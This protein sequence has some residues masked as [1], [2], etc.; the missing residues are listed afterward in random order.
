MP[1][2]TDLDERHAPEV[3]LRPDLKALGRD[4]SYIRV[5]TDNHASTSAHGGVSP[6][7]ARSAVVSPALPAL[8]VA[9]ASPLLQRCG[10]GPCGCAEQPQEEPL[11]RAP[12]SPMAAQQAE[13]PP[14]VHDALTSPGAPLAAGDR[15][16]FESRFGQDFSAVRVHTGAEA[17]DSARAVGAYGYTVGNHV[18]LGRNV[19]P[20]ATAQGRRVLAHELAHVIQQRGVRTLQARLT[21]GPADSAA[22]READVA[23]ELAAKGETAAVRERGPTAVVQRALSCPELISP[24]DQ[25]A[26]NGIGNPAHDAIEDY[27]RGKVGSRFW[28]QVIPGASFAPYRTEDPDPRH[29]EPGSREEQVE[30]QIIGGRGGPGTPDLGYREARSPVVELAEVKPAIL[31]YGAFGGLVEGAAQLANYIDKGMSPENSGWRGRRRIKTFV[32]MLPER[33]IWPNSLSTEAGRKIAVGWCGPGLVGYR[34]LSAEES[35]TIIC[36][37]SDQKQIDRFLN[38]ALDR[39]QSMV[40]SYIDRSV[41][42][43]LT[44]EIQ[45]LTIHDGLVLLAKHARGALQDLL[46]KEVG[47]GVG[48]LVD[49]LPGDELVGRAAMWIEDQVGQQAETMLRNLVLQVKTKLLTEVRRHLKDRLRTYLQESLAAVCAAA[50][51]GASVSVAQLLKKL[52]QDLGKMFGESVVEVAKA[53]A[54]AVAKELAKALLIAVLVV[55]AV[56][57]VIVF[58][59]EILAAIAAAGEFFLAA[60]AAIAAAGGAVTALGPNLQS[61]ISDVVEAVLETAPAL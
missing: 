1:V 43:M 41:D 57:A 40:D 4:F 2:V 22:E 37:V 6:M 36:G 16:F 8:T 53:W 20:I 9:P 60:G 50:A 24:T 28:Q 58:L 3:R 56:V 15:A 35:E 33:M 32:P 51:V 30:P 52:A 46:N 5:Q 12:V 14:I 18:I 27:F 34:P 7:S 45:T 25:E 61:I 23:A 44:R 38:F 47:P 10:A 55:I 26:T 17:A 31:Q 29:R 13:V 48:E 21:I 11:H 54:I 19:Q 59:P 49:V 42:A 39:A